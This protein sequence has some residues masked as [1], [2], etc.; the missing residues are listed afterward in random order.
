[1]S[2]KKLWTL[3]LSQLSISCLSIGGGLTIT[4]MIRRRFMEELHWLDT[5]EMLDLTAI[6]QAA[7][8]PSSC[9]TAVMV[10]YRICGL[11][12]ALTCAAASVIPPMALLMA[13]SALYDVLRQIELVSTILRF[14]QLGMAAYLLDICG[15]MLRE[16]LG[17]KKAVPALMMLLCLG[18]RLLFGISVAKL[19]LFCL[20]TG[21]ADMLFRRSRKEA[22]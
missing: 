20:G 9:N 18:G 3:F 8:G 2:G 17:A 10:G 13:V 4:A 11:A 22:C 16:F 1:M 14:M 19:F 21:L 12:G 5:Q 7:P 15:G 6:A